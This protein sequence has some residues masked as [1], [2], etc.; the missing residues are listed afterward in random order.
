MR[1][2]LVDDHRQRRLDGVREIAD[3][4]ARALDDLAVGVDQRIGLARERRDLDGEF[5]FQPLGAAGADVGDRFRDALQRRKAEADLEDRW[6]AAAR[7]R[8]R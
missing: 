7:C 8:A 6:S 1:G 4:G 3:M 2:G 5:A